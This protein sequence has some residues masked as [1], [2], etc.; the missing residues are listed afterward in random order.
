MVS[1]CVV[2]RIL[3]FECVDYFGTI[4]HFSG[5]KTNNLHEQN[6]Q[7]YWKIRIEHRASGIEDRLKKMDCGDVG[8]RP[9]RSL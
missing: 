9:R 3:S 5:P 6:F 4:D 8:R 7:V 1:E 2:P